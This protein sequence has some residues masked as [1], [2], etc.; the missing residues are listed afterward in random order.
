MNRLL[1]EAIMSCQAT[2][3]FSSDASAVKIEGVKE[4]SILVQVGGDPG[5]WQ[6]LHSG[7]GSL[8][9]LDPRDQH[10]IGR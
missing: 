6:V 2:G 1:S 8:F 9:S 7:C 4:T 10:S 3:A 5:E